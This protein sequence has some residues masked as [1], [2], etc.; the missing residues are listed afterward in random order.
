MCVHECMYVHHVCAVTGR[1]EET[2][3]PLELE[4]QVV[5]NHNVGAG[6]QT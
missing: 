4:L 6:N 1:S 2:S 3:H 5:L